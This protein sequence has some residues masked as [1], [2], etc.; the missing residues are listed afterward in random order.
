MHVYKNFVG[1]ILTGGGAGCINK[2]SNR[3]GKQKRVA[4][5]AHKGWIL[6]N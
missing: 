1:G 5:D 4:C 3:K 2:D 6:I